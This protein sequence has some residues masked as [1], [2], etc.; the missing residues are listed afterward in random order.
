MCKTWGALLTGGFFIAILASWQLTGHNIPPRLGWT[1]IV[2]GVIVA[3]FQVWNRQFER[4][5]KILRER[6]DKEI[7]ISLPPLSAEM[8]A[9][10]GKEYNKPE[11][12][13]KI[14]IEVVNAGAIFINRGDFCTWTET[15][16]GFQAAIMSFKNQI[17]TMAGEQNQSFDN[18]TANIVYTG[19]DKTE[20]IVYGTWL[21]EY[22]RSVQFEP[23][24]V[25]HLVIAIFERAAKKMTGFYNPKTIN[26]LRGRFR[27][28]ISLHEPDSVD[29]P[30]SPCE[31]T[32]T[33]MSFGTTI[34]SDRYVL[35]AAEDGTM[36]L[37]RRDET[38][39]VQDHQP[40]E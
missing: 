20:H 35:T 14:P 6:Q 15:S 1:L 9:E 8:I 21:D 40:R 27:S 30:V 19:M 2:G 38:K 32:V 7:P 18:V 12:A 34:F 36:D 10:F 4:A 22:T 28:G 25:R 11:P 5:E 26:P 39:I 24:E 31:V 33:L 3:G 16:H 13:H 37:K 17:A 29:L 23:G